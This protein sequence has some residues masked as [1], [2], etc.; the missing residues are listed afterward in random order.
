[1]FL[2]LTTI[3]QISTMSFIATLHLG[4]LDC[5]NSTRKCWNKL[6]TLH[7]NSVLEL[8]TVTSVVH[9]CVSV[10]GRGGLRFSL[11]LIVSEL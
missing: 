1:M 3:C 11:S 6:K 7:T 2:S 9:V 10:M 4:L 8:C 5:H